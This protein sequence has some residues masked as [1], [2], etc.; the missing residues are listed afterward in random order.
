MADYS[1]RCTRCKTLVAATLTFESEGGHEVSPP[2]I[3]G[4]YCNCA[5]APQ[6]AQAVPL[7]LR[8]APE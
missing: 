1:G 5:P 8:G 4:A 6:M 2:P 7:T 3:V